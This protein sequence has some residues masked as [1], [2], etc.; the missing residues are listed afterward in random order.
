M[1]FKK[2]IY[3]FISSVQKFRPTCTFCHASYTNFFF[4]W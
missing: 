1:K 2:P 3:F 4:T